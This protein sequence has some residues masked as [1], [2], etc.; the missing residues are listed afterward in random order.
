MPAITFSEE[1]FKAKAQ[2][3]AQYYELVCN[4]VEEK[5]GRSNPDS[6]T[7]HF[8]ISVA[9]GPQKGVAVKWYP[10]NNVASHMG[11]LVNYLKCF[12]PGGKLEKGKSYELKDTIGKHFRGYCEYNLDMKWNQVTDFMPSQKTVK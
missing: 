4:G 1:D 9:E 7:Y 2:L 11:D 3:E 8:D 10:N 12:V 5:P 6:I